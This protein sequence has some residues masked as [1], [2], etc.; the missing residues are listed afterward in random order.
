MSV[1]GRAFPRRER[2]DI[3]SGT[4]N[5]TLRRVDY[6][7]AVT[8]QV[9]IR[10]A[11]TIAWASVHEAVNAWRGRCLNAFARA[12]QAVTEALDRL[13]RD[14]ARGATV[15]LPHLVGQRFEALASAISEDGAF[16]KDAGPA[17][18]ALEAFRAHDAVRPLLCHG[19]GKISVDQSGRRTLV[20][21]MTTFKGRR[22]ERSMSVSEEGEARRLADQ[23][24]ADAQRLQS[25]LALLLPD[26]N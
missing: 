13:S 3:L 7:G 17:R 10:P 16:G 11:E 15:K 8:E 4:G 14:A 6:T 19:L 26:K 2:A 5:G 24:H 12:E 1:R 18:K 9:P 25:R 20:I 22:A 21:R 23:I